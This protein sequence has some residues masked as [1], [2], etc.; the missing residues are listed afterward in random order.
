MQ[1]SRATLA[2][3]SPQAN[4]PQAGPLTPF[5]ERVL[6][7]GEGNFLRAFV[8]WM[9]NAMNGRGLFQGRAAVVQPIPR[10]TVDLLNQQDGL[11]TCL[12]RGV[13][14]GRVVERREI[15]T[16]IS[17]GLDPYR[18]WS[19]V[20]ALVK[21]PE[22][23]FVVSNTTE[24]GIAY[25]EESRPQAA[26]P[27]SFP[28][29]VAALLYQ[30]FR[31]SGGDPRSGLVFLPCELIDRNGATLR[32]CV[33]R[34]AE[35]WGLEPGFASWVTIHNR[36][37]NTLVDRI[38]PGF[39]REEIQ[40]LTA[41]LGYEDPMLTT[42]EIF[43]V[44]VIEGDPGVAAELPLT[45]AGLNVVW[46]SDL[47]PY[48]TRK[49]RILNG[50]HTM[51]ALPAFLAGLDTVGACVKDDL[52]GAY[53]RRGLFEEI[54][55]LLPLPQAET[56]AFAEEV[57]ERL[58]N[59]FIRHELQSIALN[60]VAKYRVRVLPSLLEYRAR[61]GRLP[62]ALTFS[63]AALLAFYRGTEIRDGTLIGARPAG[64]YPIRDDLPVLQAF[65]ACWQAYG[66]ARDLAR[67]CAEILGQTA[68]WGEDLTAVPGLRAAVESNLSSI[69]A[70]GV[71]GALGTV[72]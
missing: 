55:P 54:L 27:A 24:A 37:L 26:C 44:W 38:V 9:L 64:P 22:L 45:Q 4:A 40:A 35:A 57:L 13:Q 32:A 67:L 63:L 59:P 20:V 65:A 33:L 2:A 56:R 30:R 72:A 62:A 14:G 8:D 49:V 34:H 6:Q 12:L 31:S 66:G 28:A 71:R 70:A 61:M 5:P 51:T 68:L 48:R 43:H 16:A 50:V 10:G 18:S 15:V 3:L 1:L 7:F 21:Q 36:F 46:T 11:Y 58:A 42:G 29:K 19:E 53:L 41:E 25:V 23:R 69:L 47:Q 17:R 60:S 52:L 39:P